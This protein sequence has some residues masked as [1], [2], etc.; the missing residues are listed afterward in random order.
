MMGKLSVQQQIVSN[1]A[2]L[3]MHVGLAGFFV[4]RAIEGGMKR[5]R[6]EGVKGL[7]K[8][9]DEE[10]FRPRGLRV[11]VEKGHMAGLGGVAAGMGPGMGADMNGGMGGNDY[12][13][14][15]G[16]EQW[17]ASGRHDADYD[18]DSSSSFS[19]SSDSSADDQH[20]PKDKRKG[21]GRAEQY[22]HG[23]MRG[24][25][26]ARTSMSGAMY[27]PR[28]EMM[29]MRGGRP[30]MGMAPPMSRRDAK[31]ERKEMKRDMKYARKEE[32]RE[33]RGERREEKRERRE[34]RRERKA[35]RRAERK[36]SVSFASLFL[37]TLMLTMC[38]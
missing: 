10:F 11:W 9:W 3:F 22:G 17:R 23:E 36:V 32:K 20:H 25:G 35:G 29:M 16:R 38:V 5:R 37:W 7:V 2:P 1:V 34:M 30:S 8:V 27:D 26:S 19:S 21:K 12:R 33:R 14:S 15:P 4:T 18:S 13:P 28:T 6:V 24:A 31:W